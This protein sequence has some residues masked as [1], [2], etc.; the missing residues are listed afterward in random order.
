MEEYSHEIK[1][2]S[3]NPLTNSL[4]NLSLIGGQQFFSPFQIS[5]GLFDLL[6]QS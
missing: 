6:F 5:D 1:S 4:T 3:C 2:E